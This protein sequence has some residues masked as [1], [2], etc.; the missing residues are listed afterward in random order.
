M[1]EPLCDANRSAALQHMAEVFS[2]SEPL[3][4]ALGMSAL[5]VLAFLRPI[6]APRVADDVSVVCRQCDGGRVLG[7][8]LATNFD[9]ERGA[10]GGDAGPGKD[11]SV[12]ALCAF[13]SEVEAGLEASRPPPGPLCHLA[14]ISV[15]AEFRRHGIAAALTARTLAAAA[16]AGLVGTFAEAT[17]RRSSSLFSRHFGFRVASSMRYAAW[18]PPGGGGGHPLAALAGGVDDAAAGCDL[19]V[20]W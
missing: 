20:S 12:A 8:S 3:T 13:L 14:I 10:C 19:V 17:S 16:R 18:T 5:D 7:V 6:A 1:F 9:A 15:D 11:E 4:V 2:A